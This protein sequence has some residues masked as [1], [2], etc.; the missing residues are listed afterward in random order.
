M[1][2]DKEMDLE[3]AGIDAFEFSLMDDDEKA[4]ALE[5]AGLDPYD[6]EGIEFD[7]S[8]DAWSNLQDAGLSLG[9]LEFMD[10]EEKREAL[11]KAGLDPDDYVG[12]SRLRFSAYVPQNTPS[13]IPAA[14][15]SQ[16]Y[17]YC[18]IRFAAGGQLYSYLA[19][20]L[21]LQAGDYVVVPA[22]PDNC[23]KIVEVVSVQDYARDKVPYPLEKTK[24]VLRKASREEITRVLADVLAKTI[25]LEPTEKV[26]VPSVSKQGVARSSDTH[27]TEG[28]VPDYYTQ[29]STPI[30]SNPVYSNRIS[31]KKKRSLLPYI[32][33]VIVILMISLASLGQKSTS[34]STQSYRPTTYSTGTTGSSSYRNNSNTYSSSYSRQSIPTC[35]PVNRER[36]MTK[37]EAERLSGTGYHGT[38]PNS[39]AE[40]LELAAAQTRCKNCGYRTHNGLNSLCDYCRWMETY[41]GGLPSPAVTAPAPTPKP[42]ATPKPANTPKPSHDP[43]HASDYSDPDDFYYDYYDDF[44]DFEDAE[45]YWHEHH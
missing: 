35:P 14:P 38:R 43:Y 44:W 31:Q 23:E 27:M 36:A 28:D 4:E 8:F 34:R 37:E 29:Q 18:Q 3:N 12:V 21:E 5:E 11:E 39:S 16:A 25:P 45:D 6:Y 7:S 41:G 24:K 13:I 30:S 32:A 26:V 19:D 9:D 40:N 33:A 20:D 17:R 22:G 15:T 42:R 10:D 2:F 1:D